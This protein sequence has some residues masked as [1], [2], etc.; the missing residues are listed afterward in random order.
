MEN[1]TVSDNDGQKIKLDNLICKVGESEEPDVSKRP[2]SSGGSNSQNKNDI[3]KNNKPN[4]IN[5]EIA[6]MPFSDVALTDWFYGSVKYV[7]DN[8]LMQGLSDEKFAPKEYVTRAMFVTVIYRMEG[9]PKIGESDFIDVENGIWYENAVNWANTNKIITGVSTDKFEPNLRITR[10]QI[11]TI[12]Y[13]YAQYKGYN[14]LVNAGRN[15]DTYNDVDDISEYALLAMN[16]AV[17]TSL[18]H[19]KTDLTLNPLDN[20]TRAETAVLLQR[21]IESNK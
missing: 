12:I 11:A 17:I 8:N 13:R 1:I 21:F 15:I 9:E 18:V 20:A 2:S 14:V 10:E 19:G 6:K 4:E 5:K 3:D 16:Y 7:Y